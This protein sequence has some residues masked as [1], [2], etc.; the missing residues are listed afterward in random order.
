M[1]WNCVYRAF[2]SYQHD[3]MLGASHLNDTLTY[4]YNWMYVRPQH[5]IITVHLFISLACAECDDSLPFSGASAILLCYI[6]LSTTLLHQLFFHSLSP[7]FSLSSI[8]SHLFLGLPLSLVVPKFIY[9]TL[10]GILFSS[11]LCTCPNQRNLT[12]LSLL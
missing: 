5:T 7:I 3:V 10:F 8:L 11:I 1:T 2:C 4:T 6:L 9:N 12:L